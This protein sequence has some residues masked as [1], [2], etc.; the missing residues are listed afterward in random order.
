MR[1]RS[2]VSAVHGILG[3]A[4]RIVLASPCVVCGG[5]LPWR[6]RR[7]SCCSECWESLELIG[8]RCASCGIP[9]D[10]G[11]PG[12]TFT[13]IECARSPLPLQWIDS[14]GRYEG[15][16]ERLIHAFKFEG[17]DFLSDQLGELLSRRFEE[18]AD[19]DFARV[20]A[21]PLHRSRLRRRGY[22]QSE[23]LARRF[24]RLTGIPFDGRV[25]RKRIE[26]APQS[27]L[28]RSERAANVR[29]VFEC[30]RPL[31]DSRILLIDDVCTTGE[32]LAACARALRRA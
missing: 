1:A 28:R 15:T 24:A 3:E 29:G 32:T 9:W 26:R 27:T 11:G 10:G 21:V 12:E 20:A 7:G 22:N 23:L 17:H 30:V 31:D 5:E 18:R 13:C 19:D 6:N 4:G 16:L 25:L 8:A 14:F 2:L